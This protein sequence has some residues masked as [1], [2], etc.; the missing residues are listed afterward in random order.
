MYKRIYNKNYIHPN[1]TLI[2][3][4]FEEEE[5]RKRTG[6]TRSIP[7]QNFPKKAMDFENPITNTNP[8][9]DTF[10]RIINDEIFM[11]VQK[12]INK[13]KK[14]IYCNC[15]NKYT[16]KKNKYYSKKKKRITTNIELYCRKCNI[17][18]SM[19]KHCI[20]NGVK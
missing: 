8:R 16:I 12:L 6:T 13:N 17:Y 9:D 3:N 5:L 19:N 10:K 15:G 2:H 14:E 4:W 20:K 1:G 7:N 11:S 18:V